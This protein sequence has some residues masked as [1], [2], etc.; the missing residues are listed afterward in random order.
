LWGLLVGGGGGPHG[1]CYLADQSNP[2]LRGFESP[3]KG[4][5]L[6][7]RE[8]NQGVKIPGRKKEVGVAQGSER[9]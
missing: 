3:D 1:K 2:K 9:R 5:F 7:K 4:G 6:V 8:E